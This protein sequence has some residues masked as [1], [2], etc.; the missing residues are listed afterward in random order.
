M[1]IQ[2]KKITTVTKISVNNLQN[3]IQN[4]SYLLLIRKER[5]FF[6][7]YV[8]YTNILTGLRKMK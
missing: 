4:A 8:L 3:D 5:F 2:Y 1:Q 6:S 7:S